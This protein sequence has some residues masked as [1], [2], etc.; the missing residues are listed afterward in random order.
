MR[1]SLI[2]TAAVAALLVMALPSVHFSFSSIIAQAGGD[3]E[4]GDG[5]GVS[6]G[7]GGWGDD[8]S[9]DYSKGDG[10]NSDDG[11]GEDGSG[12][13]GYPGDHH[14][15]GGCKSNCSPLPPPPPSGGG[16]SGG[17]PTFPPHTCPAGQ[18]GTWVQKG[19]FHWEWTCP[20]PKVVVATPVPK[21]RPKPKPAP[22]CTA[23]QEKTVVFF[24][25]KEVHDCMNW[26][27]YADISGNQFLLDHELAMKAAGGDGFYLTP[28][29]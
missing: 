28:H 3:G 23:C 6:E 1:V 8:G 10:D 29:N 16:S 21:P 24:L 25:K 22:V 11:S 5:S 19:A 9:D 20:K 14:D 4:A 2:L 18:I 15:K 26:Y 7:G 12:E 27:R 13:D 17:G